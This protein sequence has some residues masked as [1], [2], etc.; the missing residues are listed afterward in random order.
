MVTGNPF[1]KPPSGI[2]SLIRRN[3]RTPDPPRS[4]LTRIRRVPASPAGDLEPTMKVAVLAVLGLIGLSLGVL[5]WGL[6][7]RAKGD[8]NDGQWPYL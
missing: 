7:R 6:Y 3:H 1:R 2:H 4:T 8:P 5:A